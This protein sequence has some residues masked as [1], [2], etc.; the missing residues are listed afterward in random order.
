[1][2]HLKRGSISL[3]L[4]Q[5]TPQKVGMDLVVKLQTMQ[6]LTFLA[7]FFQLRRV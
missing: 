1:M 4:I 5:S 2:L 7:T 6:Q 3:A